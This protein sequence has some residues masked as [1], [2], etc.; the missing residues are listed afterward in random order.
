VKN[1]ELPKQTDINGT[2][3]SLV[4]NA[5]VSSIHQLLSA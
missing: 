5:A 4:I 2:I 3:C 1:S